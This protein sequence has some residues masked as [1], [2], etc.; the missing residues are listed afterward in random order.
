MRGGGGGGEGV[1]SLLKL[2]E[3]H[4]EETTN[5]NHSEV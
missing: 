3:I 2:N 5:K 4:E 1:V